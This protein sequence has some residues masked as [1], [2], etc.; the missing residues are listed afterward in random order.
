MPLAK[1]SGK[2]AVKNQ[3]YVFLTLKFGEREIITREIW[4]REIGR[5]LI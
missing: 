1:W 5:G 4:K 2:G 3:Q